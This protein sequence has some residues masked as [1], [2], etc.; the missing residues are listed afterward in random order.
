MKPPPADPF[1]SARAKLAWAC[2]RLEDLSALL[3][4]AADCTTT[5]VRIE[6][7]VPGWQM[8]VFDDQPPQDIAHWLSEILQPARASLDHATSQ[9]IS[10]ARQR[11][12]KRETFPIQA[13]A[14]ER[15]KRIQKLFGKLIPSVAQGLQEKVW[16]DQNL[17][18]SLVGLG[19]LAAADKHRRLTLT[20]AE[21]PLDLHFAI[22]EGI[23]RSTVVDCE[24]PVLNLSPDPIRHLSSPQIQIELRFGDEEE[25]GGQPVIARLRTILEAVVVT[26]NVLESGWKARD[27]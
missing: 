23:I 11:Q 16:S 15:E 7:E 20:A 8:L 9:I 17:S 14:D 25:F 2:V 3:E 27:A 1:T 19:Q 21:M 10:F 6:E 5:S 26:L 13:D 12:E 22:G 4:H 18:S 24:I